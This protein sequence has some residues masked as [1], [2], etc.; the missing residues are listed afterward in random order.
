MP[1]IEEMLM[2]DPPKFA[3]AIF[4]TGNTINVITSNLDL[5]AGLG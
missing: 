4:E 3:F 5:G 2:H 1:F